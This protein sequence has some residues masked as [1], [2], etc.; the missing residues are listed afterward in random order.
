VPYQLKVKHE[1]QQASV[2][3]VNSEVAAKVLEKRFDHGGGGR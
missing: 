3:Y 2:N 1:F